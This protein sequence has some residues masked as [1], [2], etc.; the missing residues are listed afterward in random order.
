[1]LATQLLQT[2]QR[3]QV[4]PGDLRCILV[5]LHLIQQQLLL[6]LYVI[7]IFIFIFIYSA[8]CLVKI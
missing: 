3:A 7:F 6:F 4:I 5:W 1:M 8:C 2:P